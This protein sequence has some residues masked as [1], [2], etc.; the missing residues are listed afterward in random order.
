MRVEPVKKIYINKERSVI[1]IIYMYLDDIY[2]YG[3]SWTQ[4][5]RYE[6]SESWKYYIT[7]IE[8][9]WLTYLN[10]LTKMTT[11]ENI[12]NSLKNCNPEKKVKYRN[13]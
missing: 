13:L 10:W 9:V 2:H 12:L 8:T 11:D 7:E 3:R 1:E 4:F 6:D 5:R